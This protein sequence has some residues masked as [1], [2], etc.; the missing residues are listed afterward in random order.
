MYR[1]VVSP[2]HFRPTYIDPRT[3]KW[4]I[5]AWLAACDILVINPY[6]A[7]DIQKKV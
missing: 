1:L 5:S 3:F 6:S 7:V 4:L 2:S